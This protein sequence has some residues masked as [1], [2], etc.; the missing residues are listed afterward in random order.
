VMESPGDVTTA[1]SATS[2]NAVAVNTYNRNGAAS[3][4]S[5]HL[6]VIC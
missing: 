1:R 3:D 6:W 4:R 2:T 5:F